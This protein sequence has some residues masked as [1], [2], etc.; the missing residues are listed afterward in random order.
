MCH[1][2]C[3][4]CHVSCVTC[5]LSHGQRGGVN[6]WRVCYQWGLLRLVYIG[7][8][9][10]HCTVHTSLLRRYGMKIPLTDAESGV[11]QAILSTL[12]IFRYGHWHLFLEKHKMQTQKMGVF[13]VLSIRKGSTNIEIVLG[14][15][16]YF[17]SFN[18]NPILLRFFSYFA[19]TFHWIG[20]LL[21]E[22]ECSGQS[23]WAKQFG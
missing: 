23:V 5:H 13:T 7:H 3:V 20:P 9:H 19:I 11:E 18:L 21:G 15:H 10:E 4:T 8:R 2:S 16:T 1:V 17:M 14:G 22:L 6:Q 12:N